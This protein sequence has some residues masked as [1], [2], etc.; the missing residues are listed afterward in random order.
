MTL[1]TDLILPMNSDLIKAGDPQSMQRYM[2]DLTESLTEAY[3][4]IAENVNGAMRTW[5]PTAYGLS[6]AGVGTYTKQV[7]WLRRSGILTELWFDIEWS[8]H[9]GTGGVAILMPYK[10]AK[11]TG[12][13]WVGVIQSVSASNVFGAGYTYLVW[14]CEQNTTQ[15]TIVRCGSG[16]ASAQ[17]PIAAQGGYAG[18]IQYLGQEFEN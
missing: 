3:R 13:P 5:T 7:G 6:T 2:V 18:Y 12:Q 1:P 11:S 4:Q 16:V 10:A 17:Q 9:T 14:K 8:A 15:G